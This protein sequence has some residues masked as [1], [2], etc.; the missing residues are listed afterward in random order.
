MKRREFYERMSQIDPESSEALESLAALFEEDYL[1][2]GRDLKDPVTAED[3]LTRTRADLEKYMS[4]YDGLK[5]RIDAEL[6]KAGATEA[7]INWGLFGDVEL[8]TAAYLRCNLWARKLI[9]CS[10]QILYCLAELKMI[11][12]YTEVDREELRHIQIDYGRRYG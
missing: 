1:T 3:I 6:R 12:R 11:G 8:P 9:R 10:Y 7:Q 2:G 5:D 4:R